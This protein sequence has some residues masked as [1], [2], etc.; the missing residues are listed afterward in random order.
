MKYK[1]WEEI[2]KEKKSKP[3]KDIL[4]LI[5]DMI[6]KAQEGLREIEY[7]LLP[8]DIAKE[9]VYKSLDL[10]EREIIS[11]GDFIFPNEKDKKPMELD[12]LFGHPIK[13]GNR[14]ALKLKSL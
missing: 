13:I 5:Q 14:L 11:E 12:T 10:D 6:Y 4:I 8:Y 9:I 7:I 3:K 2:I 1:T